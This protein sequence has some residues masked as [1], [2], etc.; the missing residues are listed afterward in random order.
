MSMSMS[1]QRPELWW[2]KTKGRRRAAGRDFARMEPANNIINMDRQTKMVPK[3][4]LRQR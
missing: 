2:M 1:K 4:R 3:I